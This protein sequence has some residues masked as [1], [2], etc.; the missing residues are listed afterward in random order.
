MTSTTPKFAGNL[1]GIDLAGLFAD[2]ESGGLPEGFMPA[3]NFSA[4]IKGRSPG[5]L[6]YTTPKNPSGIADFSIV[7]TIPDIA[8]PPVAPAP[9]TPTT[10]V[11]PTT[12]A[13]NYS[14][15]FSAPSAAAAPSTQYLP[16]PVL[17]VTPT[18]PVSPAAETPEPTTTTPTT[19]PT[20]PK[21]G[22][23]L[24]GQIRSAGNILSK[25]EAVRIADATGKTV[26]QV[27]SKAQGL[28]TNLGS[29]LVNAYSKGKLG[30]NNLYQAYA[31]GGKGLVAAVESLKPLTNLQMQPGT[32]YAGYSQYNVPATST[33][34]VNAGYSSTPGYTQYNPIVLPKPT[35]QAQKTNIQQFNQGG[36]NFGA[37]AVNRALE[38]G[39][40]ASQVQKAAAA[41]G[42]NLS[43]KAEKALKK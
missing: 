27:M 23:G 7:P 34:S 10:P 12:P 40:S 1:F 35:T 33:R 42:I 36:A 15:I 22:S 20:Q 6:T 26:A 8:Q 28:G 3:F 14:S 39:L 43:K 21:Y 30:P 32:M 24:S 4:N 11:A 9:V 5:T 13:Q 37:A 41:Q 38:S 16:A 17:P 29:A 25:K 31:S 19:T 18:A 2:Q